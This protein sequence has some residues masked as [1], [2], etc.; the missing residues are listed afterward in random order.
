MYQPR[1]LQDER[2]DQDKDNKEN[3]ME[4]DCQTVSEVERRASVQIGVRIDPVNGARDGPDH[5]A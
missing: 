1:L 2:D 4:D 3:F 5:G